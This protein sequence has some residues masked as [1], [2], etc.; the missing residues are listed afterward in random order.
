MT[1]HSAPPSAIAPALA[2]LPLAFVPLAL[3]P[4]AIVTLVGMGCSSRPVETGLST[5]PERPLAATPA[6]STGST[7]PIPEVIARAQRFRMPSAAETTRRAGQPHASPGSAPTIVRTGAIAGG[8]TSSAAARATPL[9]AAAPLRATVPDQAT[10]PLQAAVPLAA[11][12]PG[13]LD[14]ACGPDEEGIRETM[15]S[16]LQ[17]FNRHDPAALA[18]HW[19]DAGENI[20]LDSG[21]TTSGRESVRDV[22]AALFEE[23]AGASID[24]ELTS[25][26]PVADDVAVV[27]GV[28]R[29][30]FTDAP[31]SSSRFAAVMLRR[32][33]GWV[34]DTVRESAASRG[35]GASRPLDELAWLVG[36]WED[37]GE[38]VT[39]STQCFWSANRSFLV[40]SHLVSSDAVQEQRPLPGDARI[41]GLLP[42]GPPGKREITEIVGWDPDRG[43]IRSW[44]FTSAG[45]FADG[46][47]SRDGDAWTVRLEGP[48]FADAA[49]A[50]CTLSRMGDDE[51]SVR[52]GGPAVAEFLPPACDFLRTARSAG[53]LA[54]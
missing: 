15:R 52:C 20:D 33:G 17:A 49:D 18:A 34:I 7:R 32:D 3:V 22:F 26:R 14:R 2:L 46:V 53:P 25:I 27:D 11:V 42:A 29:I 36:Q 10:V 35:P 19:S 44:Y 12:Q 5:T 50:T 21:E 38:G 51:L 48:G 4:L 40:R 6:R 45:R 1:R 9:Q 39:A 54:P 31:E 23:D 37:A 24:I 41:P 13:L 43:Q 16:Y 47:W 8:A 30:S 28:S